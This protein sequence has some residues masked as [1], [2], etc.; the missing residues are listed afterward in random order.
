[1]GKARWFIGIALLALTGIGM[2]TALS[3]TP[4]ASTPAE[5]S[6]STGP[7][8]A[9]N[10]P[11]PSI[12]VTKD[13]YY[14]YSTQSSGRNIQV[15]SSNDLT[16]WGRPGDA[17]PVLPTWAEVGLTW[18]PAVSDDPSGGYEMFF[19]AR[20][21]TLGVQCIGRATAPSP[22]GPFIDSNNQPFLCQTSL[23]GSIDPYVFEDAGTSYLIWKSDGANGA[24]QQ[25]WSQPLDTNQ[26]AL[27]GSPSLLLSAT[28]RW[29]AGVVEGPAMLQT[30]SGLFLYFSGNRWS[31]SAY[32][33]GVV[34]CDTPLGPC[35]NAPTGQELSTKSKLSGP[36]GATFFVANN[37]QT[38]MAFAA[39]TGDPGAA[40]ARR[41]LYL[42]YV[43]TE[44]VQP[45]LIE[46]LVPGR[47]HRAVGD[48]TNSQ[49]RLTR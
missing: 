32:S 37:G 15:I 22:Q 41:E 8:Y 30:G 11:D 48:T 16:S 2:A 36:G 46:V 31:T 33:I 44:G 34:G 24:P 19:V 23:G 18:A 20:D 1:M 12:L 29:E 43:D 26:S 3:G 14:A 5:V 7:I 28:S 42:A 10:F 6:E 49:R 38:M 47:S 17:L 13:R 45:T 27:V 9:G 21:R 25:L 40:N 35:V 39:W 4:A